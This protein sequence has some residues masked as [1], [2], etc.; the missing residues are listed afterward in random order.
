MVIICALNVLFQ[1]DTYY[2][3]WQQLF[4]YYKDIYHEAVL[5]LTYKGAKSLCLIDCFFWLLISL[6]LFRNIWQ[7]LRFSALSIKPLCSLHI[8]LSTLVYA[9]FSKSKNLFRTSC[10]LSAFRFC[11]FSSLFSF[12]SLS[13]RCFPLNIFQ[14]LMFSVDYVLWYQLLQVPSLQVWWHPKYSRG[15]VTG[16]HQKCQ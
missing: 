5:I 9:F 3:N 15:A 16:P 11:H 13:F 6:H 14:L 12:P 10:F 8:H 1:L 2:I 7:I 4:E